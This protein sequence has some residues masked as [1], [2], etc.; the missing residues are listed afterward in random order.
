[1]AD[2]QD[3][4]RTAIQPGATAAG[5]RPLPEALTATF[6][7]QRYRPL[8]FLAEGGLGQVYVA[9]DDELAREVVLKRL[10]AEQAARPGTAERFRREAE[11]TGRLEH[12][13]VVP[14]YG[15]VPDADGQ[16]CYAMRFIEGESLKD[17]LDRFHA[18]PLGDEQGHGGGDFP[19]RRDAAALIK[20]VNR[21]GDRA[22]AQRRDPVVERI[23]PAVEIGRRGK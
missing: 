6:A 7:G 19:Q 20:A 18:A 14:V 21:F 4:T 10:R 1:M 8:R 2:E 17:A 22:I 3:L 11:L 23:D 16:P 5:G 13:G 12:P 15:L 9:A